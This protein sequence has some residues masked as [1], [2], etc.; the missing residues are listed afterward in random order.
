M[1]LWM[2]VACPF[3]KWHSDRGLKSCPQAGTK[4]GGL[5]KSTSFGQSHQGH[6]L[7]EE[8]S[9][10]SLQPSSERI[11]SVT[12]IC[13]GTGICS[14]EQQRCPLSP[15]VHLRRVQEGENT[16]RETL[17]LG[18]VWAKR[19]GWSQL[20]TVGTVQQTGSRFGQWKLQRHAEKVAGLWL[21]LLSPEGDTL[22]HPH[23]SPS[24]AGLKSPRR[25]QRLC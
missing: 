6:W 12:C 10:I 19:R 11:D 1:Y 3:S 23:W 16:F 14:P 24:A 4:P 17:K 18:G 5:V 7:W 22:P 15:S 13:R 25:Q 21:A 9:H 2:V 20:G 8:T